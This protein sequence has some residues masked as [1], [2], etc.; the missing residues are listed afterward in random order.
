MI[1]NQVASPNL[2]AKAITRSIVSSLRQ[3]SKYFK[4]FFKYTVK[5]GTRSYKVF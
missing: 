5:K 2:C 4:I 1:S 3:D